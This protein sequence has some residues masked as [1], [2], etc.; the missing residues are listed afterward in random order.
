VFLTTRRSFTSDLPYG[1]VVFIGG[2]D[3]VFNWFEYSP[4][5]VAVRT[6]GSSE[7][8]SKEMILCNF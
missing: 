5:L 4:Y 6:P 7:D 3:V 1:W 8:I 2:E